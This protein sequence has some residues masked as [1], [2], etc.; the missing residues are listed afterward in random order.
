VLHSVVQYL[1]PD[2]AR[3]LFLFFHRLLKRNGM[4]IVSDVISPTIPAIIDALALLR[5][6]AAHGFLIAAFCGLV[7]IRLSNYWRLRTRL[8]LTRYGEAA[9]I[10]SSPRRG[11]RRGAPTKIWA[12]RSFW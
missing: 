8:G 5:F 1:T 9:M 11:S 10:E 3:R 6:G 12:M 7:R 2:E 4:L